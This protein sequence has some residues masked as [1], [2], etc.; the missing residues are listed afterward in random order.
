MAGR[1]RSQQQGR[2]SAA[3]EVYKRQVY[4]RTIDGE[5]SVQPQE[6]TEP[7]PNG[8]TGWVNRTLRAE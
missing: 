1:P 3:S 7:Y 8:A 6:R 5:G 2:S 4:A